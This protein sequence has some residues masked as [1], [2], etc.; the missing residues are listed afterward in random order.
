M[1]HNME[2]LKCSS[3]EEINTFLVCMHPLYTYGRYK[4]LFILLSVC[5]QTE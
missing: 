3:R 2:D 1:N 4:T 5:S